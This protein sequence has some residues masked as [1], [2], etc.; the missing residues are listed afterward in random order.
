VIRRWEVTHRGFPRVLAT[1]TEEAGLKAIPI[2]PYDGKP[3][4]MAVLD[5]RPVVY[6]VGMDGHDDGALID[7]RYDRA[8]GDL[9][10]RLKP[11][12]R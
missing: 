1:A 3:M 12:L 7:S 8:P 11:V 10:F 4:R 5:G 9:I 6:S 2:D